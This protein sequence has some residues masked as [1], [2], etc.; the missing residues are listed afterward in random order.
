[1]Y[2]EGGGGAGQRTEVRGSKAA[3]AARDEPRLVQGKR[4]CRMPHAPFYPRLL[5]YFSSVALWPF[6]LVPPQSFLSLAGSREGWAA[7]WYH[8]DHDGMLGDGRN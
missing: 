1:M 5:G 2:V 7:A 3:A 6:D 4:A 8:T